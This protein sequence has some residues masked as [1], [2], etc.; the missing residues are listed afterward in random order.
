MYQLTRLQNGLT[1]ATAEMPH[2]ASVS[3]GLWIGVGGRYEPAEL[4]GVSHFIEH[5]M[6]KGTRRRSAKEISQ[7]VEGIGGLLATG[8]ASLCNEWG[9]P[10]EDFALADLFGAHA[11]EK[12]AATSDP[13]RRRW[14]SETQHTYLRLTPELNQGSA[15]GLAG[16]QASGPSGAGR[17]PALLSRH[18][19]LR[20]F[21]ETDLLPFGGGLTP[22]RVE[23]GAKVLLTFVPAFP[24]Y[25][26][27]T[28]WMRE[29]RTDVPGLLLNEVAGRGRVAF[30]PADLDRRFARDNLPDHGDLLANLIRW[31][32]RG[33]FPLAVEGPGLID[34]HL[35]RQAGRRILHLVNLTSAGTWRQPVHELIPVG[36]LRVRVQAPEGAHRRRLRLLVSGAKS[37]ISVKN[38]WSAFEVRSV[39]DHEVAVL[40]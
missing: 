15:S 6:F 28:A 18:A 14:A 3:L 17:R 33:N 38:G 24:I 5:L 29:P 22:L 30:L 32:A 8:E 2:M 34:C 36:P 16:S 37:A 40:E 19:V 4:N 35:Y 7:A 23:A 12:R 26:P 9:E 1:V 31:A 20:G 39:L 13:Q 10:R 21:E 25:P 27:E 11:I